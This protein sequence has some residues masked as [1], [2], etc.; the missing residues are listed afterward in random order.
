MQLV[1]NI[2]S[3]LTSMGLIAIYILSVIYSRKMLTSSRRS[4]EHMESTVI[5]ISNGAVTRGKDGM[6]LCSFDLENIGSFPA[7]DISVYADII[8]SESDRDHC[9]SLP[10]CRVPYPIQWMKA[11][12]KISLT[13]AVSFDK[14]AAEIAGGKTVPD[15]GFARLCRGHLGLINSM[16]GCITLRIGAYFR[17]GRGGYFESAVDIFIA[18]EDFAAGIFKKQYPVR[19]NAYPITRRQF[20]DESALRA[21]RGAALNKK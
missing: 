6:L 17:N 9:M 1:I 2:T 3:I 10:S 13:D 14:I 20:E 18:P 5:A 15:Q 11:G 4:N 12:E 16:G 21:K 7:V 8:I 19:F